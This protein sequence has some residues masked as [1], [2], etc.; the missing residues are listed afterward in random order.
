MDATNFRLAILTYHHVSDEIDYYTCVREKHFYNQIR[1]FLK[2]FTHISLEEAFTL[3][4]NN[5]DASGKFV[6]TFDDGYK[7]ILPI[8]K[9]LSNMHI[10]TTIFIPTATIGSDNRW[11]YKAP[12][13]SPILTK[14]DM[15]D[16]VKLRHTFGSHGRT[17]QC[18]IKLSDEELLD[19]VAGSRNDLVE[20]LGKSNFFFAYPFG[21]YNNRVKNIVKKYYSCA[22]ATNKTAFHKN[23][24]LFQISRFS[25]N[26]DTHLNEIMDYLYGSG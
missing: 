14:N 18:L 17:H 19:E 21:L 3:Y 2:N 24:D 23:L 20:I 15:K 22:F 10:K 12:Y 8:L 26:R 16:L 5:Q 13:I 9:E 6:I 1:Y 11:N 7:D 25:V 4:K